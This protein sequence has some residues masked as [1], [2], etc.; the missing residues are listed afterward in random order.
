YRFRIFGY[1]IVPVP[2]TC[3]DAHDWYDDKDKP[4]E[5]DIGAV[6]YLYGKD[7]FAPPNR[8]INPDYTVY[9]CDLEPKLC[10]PLTGYSYTEK[11]NK[12]NPASNDN[13]HVQIIGKANNRNLNKE[14]IPPSSA[15]QVYNYKNLGISLKHPPDWKFASL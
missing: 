10:Q 3:T 12:L 6:I 5:F 9:K 8:I 15:S 11:L 14:Q 13:N 2:E 4:S 7:G 1:G